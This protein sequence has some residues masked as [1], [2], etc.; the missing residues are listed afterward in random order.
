MI[1]LLSSNPTQLNLI[2]VVITINHEQRRKL[3]DGYFFSNIQ[4][5][6]LVYKN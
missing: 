4:L 2:Y 1:F 3:E 5:N 6:V